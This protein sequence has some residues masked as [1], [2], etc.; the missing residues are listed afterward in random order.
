MEIEIYTLVILCIKQITNENLLYTQG[1]LC[2]A[3]HVYKQLLH[4]TVQQN[5]THHCKL[6]ISSKLYFKNNNAI[7][8]KETTKT[9][10]RRSFSQAALRPGGEE[11]LVLKTL[12]LP[13]Q[14]ILP[15]HPVK[16][17]E[18]L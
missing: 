15:L 7:L 4:F 9:S 6:S 5:L 17:H 18:P 12:Q 3:P 14:T 2:S 8:A 10:S 13:A 11:D 1:I 16:G